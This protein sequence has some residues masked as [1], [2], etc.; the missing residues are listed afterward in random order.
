MSGNG[1][2]PKPSPSAPLPGGQTRFLL[3]RER[4]WEALPL[5]TL[6][7]RRAR[8]AGS[9]STTQPASL[10]WRAPGLK[11]GQSPLSCSGCEGRST[12][13]DTQGWAIVAARE[14]RLL[15]NHTRHRCETAGLC[16]P[17]CSSVKGGEGPH[18]LTWQHLVVMTECNVTRSKK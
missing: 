3:T 12:L 14:K 17:V 11:Q 9:E 7:G 15:G 6:T 8:V 10:G 18:P 2:L 16:E 5:G 1:S 4:T 13:K